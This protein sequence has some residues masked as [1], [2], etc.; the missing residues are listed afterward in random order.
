MHNINA[1]ST[2]NLLN[3]PSVQKC[4]MHKVVLTATFEEQAHDKTYTMP[5]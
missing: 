4:K 5:F 3:L 2:C 1:S